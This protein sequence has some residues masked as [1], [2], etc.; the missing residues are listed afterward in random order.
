MN[1]GK[2]DSPPEHLP[3]HYRHIERGHQRIEKIC[4][5]FGV[6]QNCRYLALLALSECERVHRVSEVR[7]GPVAAMLERL[8]A[9]T[10]TASFDQLLLLCTCDYRAYPG[11]DGRD[12]SKAA[13]LH[14]A[15]KACASI[16]K[17]GLNDDS[18]QEARAMAI[19]V[20][21]RSE[22]WSESQP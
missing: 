11:Y 22:R 7:A 17:T 16:D 18:L 14:V 12:Y 2:Y 6:P 21:F 8:G 15:L 13:L 5:R 10:D 3:V 4:T 1:V 19:A 9:F 20:A